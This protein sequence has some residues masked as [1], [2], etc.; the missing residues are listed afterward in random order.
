MQPNNPEL[1][2]EFCST[3]QKDAVPP[4]LSTDGFSTT[5]PYVE[6]YLWNEIFSQL[7]E[8]ANFLKSAGFFLWESD[9]AY[10]VDSITRRANKI[11][12]AKLDNN[13]DPI[14]AP[15]PK[16]P[17]TNPDTW[18]V[19]LDLDNP[20]SKLYALLGGS[21][22][23]A[24]KV[25]DAAAD[26]EAVNK[27]QLDAKADKGGNALQRFLVAAATQEGEAV[28][29][30]QLLA[31]ALKNG[32]AAEIF[33]VKA[34]EAD[35]DAVNLAQL[36]ASRVAPG[37]VEDFAGVA[38]PAGYLVCDQQQ[39]LITEYQALFDA[40]GHTWATTGGIAAPQQGYF[41]V[42]PQ[43]IDGFGLFSRG[44]GEV[45]VGTYQ[46]D[47]NKAH[48]HGYGRGTN[49]DIAGEHPWGYTGLASQRKTDQSGGTEARPHSV[50]F[51]KIIKY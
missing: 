48:D 8:S 14:N 51:L 5:N 18:E 47:Q 33:K 43:E 26:E 12:F 1:L 30:T 4:Y 41:R 9:R 22:T 11:Y 15:D 46:A 35:E 38:A 7:F 23:Q 6:G 32:S 27:K 17:A 3:G 29:F 2:K 31:R 39:Y 13:L 40:I 10:T 19:L 44:V 50:T 36:N 45:Q 16:D 20:P 42:P 34:G 49:P 37:I 21:A 24:F 28:E 25:K